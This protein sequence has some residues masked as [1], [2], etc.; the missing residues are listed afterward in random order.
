MNEEQVEVLW[1]CLIAFCF[2]MVANPLFGILGV[3]LVLFV[4]K[5]Y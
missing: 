2:G 3:G 5:F 4:K 1:L